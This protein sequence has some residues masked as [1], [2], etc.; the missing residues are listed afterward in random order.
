MSVATPSV[1]EL[2]AK[3]AI[4]EV[5]HRYYRG[6][7]RMD[8][9]LT[10]RAHGPIG[11]VD[12]V[13]GGRYLDRLE[14]MEGLWAFRH[15]QSVHDWDRVDPVALTLSDPSAV[16]LI[17]PN[18]PDAPISLSARDASDPSYRYLQFSASGR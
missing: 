10:L 14:C 12:I 5:I 3:Q 18:N 13:G 4:T 9:E 8:R 11:L 7:D 16:P 1:H 2:Q 17:P 6:M 15:R